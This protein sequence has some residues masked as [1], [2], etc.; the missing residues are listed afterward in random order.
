M[1]IERAIKWGTLVSFS[2]GC[3]VKSMN[4][5][6]PHLCHWSRVYASVVCSGDTLREEKLW[7]VF[8]T[9]ILAESN[10]VRLSP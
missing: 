2:G 8:T 1:D 5:R 6:I 7:D 10:A 3:I 9:A 4:V